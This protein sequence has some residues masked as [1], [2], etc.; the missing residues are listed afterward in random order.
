MFFVVLLAGCVPE[1]EPTDAA[2]SPSRTEAASPAPTRTKTPTPTPTPT[3]TNEPALATCDSIATQAQ[4]DAMATR[5]FTF[6]EAPDGAG[7]GN[8]FAVFPNGIP[9]GAL[10]CV[11][12]TS[13]DLATDDV[14]TFA[15]TPIDPENGLAA[16]ALL[17]RQGYTRIE[18]AEGVYLALRGELGFMDTEGWSAT[19]LFT[20]DDVRWAETKEMVSTFVKAP[21]ESR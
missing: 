11:W 16:E 9:F 17:E 20:A 2:P 19:Y 7:L 12:G 8:P 10:R 5:S 21:D 3:T 4:L 6:W 18:A 1:P 15:W 13:P 14:L